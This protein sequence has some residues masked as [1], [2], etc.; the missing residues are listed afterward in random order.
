MSLPENFLPPSELDR[1]SCG[2]HEQHVKRVEAVL[3]SHLEGRDVVVLGTWA[4][5]AV[6]RVDGGF[7]RFFLEESPAGR[8][9]V[10]EARSVVVQEAVPRARDRWLMQAREIAELFLRGERPLMESR[11]RGLVSQVRPAF[12]GKALLETL[13]WHLT[14][15][16]TWRSV[17][18][19]QAATD[20]LLSES[21]KAPDE[22]R[23]RLTFR[24]LYD[25]SVAV[26][27]DSY[28]E[29]VSEE[30]AWVLDRSQ[31][32]LDETRATLV[33]ARG[34][35]LQEKGREQVLGTFED[36][37][38]DLIDDLRTLHEVGSRAAFDL[39]DLCERARL[40][41]LLAQGLRE[42]GGVCRF[43]AVVADRLIS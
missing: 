35:L 4:R 43:V 10:R 42:R 6:A 24:A 19:T 15:P 14:A 17:V 3:R 36:F 9:Q 23:L 28:S 27:P 25:G 41:D 26:D 21:E 16:R 37:A 1:L 31:Q 30:L 34:V 29:R 8:L 20:T 13:E 40:H 33:S 18:Q 7:F 39:G 12:T 22:D 2:S 11:L 5:E 32:V 38:T